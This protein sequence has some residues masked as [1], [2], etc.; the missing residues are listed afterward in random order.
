MNTQSF[1][2]AGSVFWRPVWLGRRGGPAVKLFH[3]DCGEIVTELTRDAGHAPLDARSLG[4]A[5]GPGAL[6][7]T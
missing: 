4:A 1:H 6:G 5:P 2:S 3:R 7:V